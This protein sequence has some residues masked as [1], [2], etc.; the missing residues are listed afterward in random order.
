MIF[1]GMVAVGIAAGYFWGAWGGLLA[2]G[3][4]IL[5]CGLVDYQRTIGS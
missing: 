3:V 5:L 1:I 4:M 2:F